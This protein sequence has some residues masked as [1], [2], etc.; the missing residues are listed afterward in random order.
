MSIK[1]LWVSMLVIGAAVPALGATGL[2][3]VE[4]RWLQGMAPVLAYARQTQLPLDIVVQPQAADGEAPLALG[5]VAGRCKL[6]L[7]MRG[8]P[9]AEATLARIAPQLHDAAL[10]LMAAHELGHCRRHLDGA[11]HGLPAGFTP[12][13]EP[14]GW[15]PALQQA[16]RHMRSTRREEAYGDLVGLSWVRQQQPQHYHR[17]HAWLLAERERELLP[18]SHHDTLAWLKLAEDPLALDGDGASSAPTIFAAAQR[19]WKTGLPASE[20]D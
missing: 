4:S 19:L 11:W 17:L 1:K 10:E 9:Q 12:T 15:S 5:F 7:T 3:A 6:V 20:A 8:N 16:Y 14:Q 13:T 2:T 18:G